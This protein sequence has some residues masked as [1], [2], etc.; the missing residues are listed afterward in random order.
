M[1]QKE[2]SE[3]KMANVISQA[4]EWFAAFQESSLYTKL[5]TSAQANSELV[6][7]SFSELMYKEE[8]RSGKEWTATTLENILV[9]IFPKEVSE[10]G[11]I[12]SDIIAILTA[13]F[14]FLK[15]DGKI[16]NADTLSR[17]LAKLSFG[18]ATEVPTPTVE[19]TVTKKVAPATKKA[20]K[21]TYSEED[22]QRF[23]RFA[24]G[25]SINTGSVA[26]TP[27]VAT[28]STKTVG[29]NEPCPCGSG[30]K[31]KKCHGK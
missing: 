3:K 28:T 8:L 23:N 20:T 11:N 12:S 6:I 5:N 22:V 25:N 14:E 29:R 9:N 24:M 15:E 1:A 30:K 2:F 18:E 21:T 7:I 27:K 16:S 19:K 13:Y 17:K 10:Y 26:A 4:N 31:F